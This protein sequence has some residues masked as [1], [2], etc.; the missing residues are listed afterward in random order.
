M[1]REALIL[2]VNIEAGFPILTNV[3]TSQSSTRSSCHR[4]S[5]ECYQCDQPF[6]T[7]TLKKHKKIEAGSPILTNMH[8]NKTDAHLIAALA[9][10]HNVPVVS[11]CSPRNLYCCGEISALTLMYFS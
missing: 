8:S 5:F 3:Q 1:G 6:A 9:E 10:V 4:R 7:L 2:S 11:I